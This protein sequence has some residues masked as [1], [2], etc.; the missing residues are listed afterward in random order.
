MEK[1]FDIN[2][3]VWVFM[4]KLVDLVVL[5]GLWFLC[6]LP[7]FTIGAST[8]AL[9][10]VTMRLSK[11]EESYT[12]SSFFREWKAGCIKNSVYGLIALAIAV[13]LSSDLYVYWHLSGKMGAF[14]FS[15][16]LVLSVVYL[17][18]L[19]YFFPL[20][21]VTDYR[22]LELVKVSFVL[23]FKN[24]GWSLLMLLTMVCILAVG[25][26]VAAPLLVIGIG[27]AAY[28]Q[29]KIT[30]FLIKHYHVKT[31]NLEV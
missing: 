16:F 26:F 8:K 30:S 23:A 11:N 9:Y 24:P 28:I 18:I 27:L 10:M 13:F 19:V 6:S 14:L 2:N 7:V 29:C 22:G 12:I 31:E 20:M 3:P 1:F 17:M 21:A 4:G 15:V 5:T 25:I